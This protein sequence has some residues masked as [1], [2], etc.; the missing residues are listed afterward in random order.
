M[1]YCYND[2]S[3]QQVIG[4]GV[5]GIHLTRHSNEELKH[6]IALLTGETTVPL[7]V[8]LPVKQPLQS[9]QSDASTLATSLR[10]GRP[11]QSTATLTSKNDSRN[12]SKD[13]RMLLKLA[14]QPN[15]F[16]Y[17]KSGNKETW[18][19]TSKNQAYINYK[20]D[21]IPKIDKLSWKQ[22]NSLQKQGK[23]QCI[24]LQMWLFESIWQSQLD[25]QDAIAADSYYKLTCWPRPLSNKG[26]S[27]ALRLAA[28]AQKSAVTVADLV[29]KTHYSE[30]MVR[31][32]LYATLFVGQARQ[33]KYSEQKAVQTNEQHKPDKV[34]LGLLQRLRKKLG[35]G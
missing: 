28:F 20:R 13:Y 15:V 30:S 26:R 24:K 7:P 23:T 29:E 32:F 1:I 14:K 19:C 3:K 2:R 34:K 5:S 16:L 8:H 6:W 35:F 10:A 25:G 17:A 9:K 11:I 21:S 27:E 22:Q 31:R 12:L 18:I 33:A 4:L